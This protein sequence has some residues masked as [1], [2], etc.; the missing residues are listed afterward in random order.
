[1]GEAPCFAHF[2][3]DEGR[4]PD[5]PKIEIR[6]VYDHKTAGPHEIRVLVDRVW[7]RGVSKD[8]LHLER[9]AKDVAPSATL[10]RWFAH[11]PKRWAGF[12][13]RYRRELAEN[14]APLRELAQLATKGTLVLLYGAHDEEHNQAVVLRDVL[15]EG[16]AHS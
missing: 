7:P 4:M 5:P 2:L 9:W 13:T 16:I 12:Q 14:T 1:M 8:S 15:E 10:R 6:R 11:D 3:D